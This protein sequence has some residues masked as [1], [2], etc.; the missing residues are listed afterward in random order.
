MESGTKGVLTLQTFNIKFNINIDSCDIAT[1]TAYMWPNGWRSRVQL[2]RSELNSREG[3]YY[4]SL[5]ILI[6]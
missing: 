1:L 5:S 2:Q 6:S 3:R 4:I